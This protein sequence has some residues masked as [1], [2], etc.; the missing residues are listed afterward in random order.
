MA[1]DW[2]QGLP[3]RDPIHHVYILRCSD[4]SVYVGHTTNLGARLEAHNAGRGNSRRGSAKSFAS[5]LALAW[6]IDHRISQAM[7]WLV[8]LLDVFQHGGSPARTVNRRPGNSLYQDGREL[9][10]LHPRK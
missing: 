3:P 6:K 4:G 8:V 7:A 2:P 1:L 10:L 9:L 5:K